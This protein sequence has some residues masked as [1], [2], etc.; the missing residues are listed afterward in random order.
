MKKIVSSLIGLCVLF[1]MCSGFVG[2][3][4]ETPESCWLRCIKAKQNGKE[5]ESTSCDI[6]CGITQPPQ[7]ETLSMSSD[8]DV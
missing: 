4:D 1:T 2:S 6:D 3:C 8:N 5:P 7:E